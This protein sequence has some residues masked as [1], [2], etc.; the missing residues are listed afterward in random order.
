MKQNTVAHLSEDQNPKASKS[1]TEPE[2]I[3][4]ALTLGNDAGEWTVSQLC[5]Q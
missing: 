2:L 4:E 3:P 5:S 1:Q